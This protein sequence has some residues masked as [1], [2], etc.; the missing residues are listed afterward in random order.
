[1]SLERNLRHRQ[2]KT[3]LFAAILG[4]AVAVIG[5]RTVDAAQPGDGKVVPA[6]APITTSGL[7]T[8][9]IPF[10][11]TA[12]YQAKRGDTVIS[13]ARKYLPQTSYLT[14]SGLVT[15][16]RSANPELKGAFVKSGQEITIPGILDSPIVEKSVPVARDFEVRAIY[17]TGLMAGS[18]HGDGH[19][20]P[21]QEQP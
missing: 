14:S 19:D 12:L 6:S 15:A 2:P 3:I 11:G 4:V 18:D 8:P 20:R 5:F 9:R 16:M 10:P 17:L 7:A 21:Q 13:V 1:M